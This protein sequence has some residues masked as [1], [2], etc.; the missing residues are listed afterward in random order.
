M[1]VFGAP[2]EFAWVATRM[3]RPH[4]HNARRHDGRQSEPRASGITLPVTSL[5]HNERSYHIGTT[6]ADTTE[7]A[8]RAFRM[9]DSPHHIEKRSANHVA[10]DA[11]RV[12]LQLPPR[13]AASESAKIPTISRAE[14]GQL[15]HPMLA[16]GHSRPEKLLRSDSFSPTSHPTRRM[17][18][19]KEL[20]R[21]VPEQALVGRAGPSALAS[22]FS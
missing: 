20:L 4:R 13:R 14:G 16:S 9:R 11:E 15:Q 19:R 7:R 6:R 17:S 10:T 22:R 2:V 1:G 8:Q 5:P 12:A 21:G 18:V 3:R